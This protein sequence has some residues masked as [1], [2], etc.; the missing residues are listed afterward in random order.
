MEEVP[1][2]TTLEA[3]KI[4]K[5]RLR[6]VLDSLGYLSDTSDGRMAATFTLEQ[7]WHVLAL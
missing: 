6:C 2:S 3:V 7:I 5:R 4:L 1:R